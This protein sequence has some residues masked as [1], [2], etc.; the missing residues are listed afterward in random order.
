MFERAAK[1]FKVK[2]IFACCL[3]NFD[4][5]QEAP[6]FFFSLYFYFD[7]KYYSNFPFFM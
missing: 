4:N 3:G 7:T 1:V 6:L 2:E 5:F